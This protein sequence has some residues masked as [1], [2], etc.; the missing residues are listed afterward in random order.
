MRDKINKIF[1]SELGQQVEVLYSTSDER[2][3]LRHSEARLHTEGLLDENTKPLDDKE[4]KHW[5]REDD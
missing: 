1:N 4:I 5:Y 3:F 2:V